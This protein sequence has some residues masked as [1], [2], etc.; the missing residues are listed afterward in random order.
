MKAAP[1]VKPL[2]ECKSIVGIDV[3]INKLVALSD[4]SFQEN[5]RTT[6]NARTARRL[7]MRQ[8]AI[9]RKRKGSKNRIKAVKKLAL[10]KHTLAQ[11]RDGYG[12][13]SPIQ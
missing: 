12:W 10:Q 3:G 6:T 5:K 7:A 11:Y 8:R 1:S 2:E 9:S 4:D 13:Q